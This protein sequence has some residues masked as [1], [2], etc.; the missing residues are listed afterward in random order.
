MGVGSGLQASSGF[1][2]GLR[3]TLA[4]DLRDTHSTALT[5]TATTNLETYAGLMPKPNKTTDDPTNGVQAMSKSKAS[6]KPS[7]KDGES[8]VPSGYPRALTPTEEFQWEEAWKSLRLAENM[9][10]QQRRARGQEVLRE[11]Q[12]LMFKMPR[13]FTDSDFELQYERLYNQLYR[14]F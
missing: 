1:L 8:S 2:S 14:G 11:A 4:L 5:A 7:A 10:S 3:K 13:W 12:S 9:L 6:P